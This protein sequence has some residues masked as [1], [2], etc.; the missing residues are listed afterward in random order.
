MFQTTEYLENRLKERDSFKLKKL[1]DAE[2]K[3][4]NTT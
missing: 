4:S 3:I 1:D 2:N